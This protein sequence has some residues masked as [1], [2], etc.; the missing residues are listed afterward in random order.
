M[1]ADNLARALLHRTHHDDVNSAA[2]RRRQVGPLLDPS[3]DHPRMDQTDRAYRLLPTACCAGSTRLGGHAIVVDEA[4]VA[5]VV[6]LM[7]ISVAGL[8]LRHLRCSRGE[9]SFLIVNIT[10]VP[11]DSLNM[12]LDHRHSITDVTFGYA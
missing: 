12:S 5:T 6:I 3:L 2:T 11:R 8:L 10:S 7:T 1:S 4:K 9:C